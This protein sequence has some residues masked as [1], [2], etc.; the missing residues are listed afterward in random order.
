[1][2]INKLSPHLEMSHMLVERED[3]TAIV[4]IFSKVK[5]LHIGRS[6]SSPKNISRE[7]EPAANA[8]T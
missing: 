8:E 1:M 6:N 3:N 2:H 4:G 7:W 5:Q